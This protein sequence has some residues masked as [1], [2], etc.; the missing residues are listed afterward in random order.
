MN[1]IGNQ[2]TFVTNSVQNTF[3]YV[4][5]KK[6]SHS[7]LSKWWHNLILGGWTIPLIF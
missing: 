7:G 4:P 6:V 1:V 3:F 5:Q 2:N